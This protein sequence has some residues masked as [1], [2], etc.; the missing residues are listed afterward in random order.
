MDISFPMGTIF[1]I[2]QIIKNDAFEPIDR[3]FYLMLSQIKDNKYILISMQTGNRWFKKPLKGDGNGSVNEKDLKEYLLNFA[4][5]DIEVI[6][7]CSEIDYEKLLT[8][9]Q[10]AVE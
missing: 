5:S 9:P 2:K 4:I 6:G 8:T 3:I 1:R 10:T 7:H